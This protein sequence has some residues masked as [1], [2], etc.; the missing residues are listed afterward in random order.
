MYKIK[1]FS[2]FTH[3]AETLLSGLS[4]EKVRWSEIA[5]TLRVALD[6]VIG[7]IL[8][9]SAFIAF[10]GC[11][12]RPYRNNLLSNWIG[13][14]A[15]LDIQC[16]EHFKLHLTLNDSAEIRYWTTSEL[17]MDDYAVESAIVVRNSHR[18]P[19][20]IDPQGIQTNFSCNYEGLIN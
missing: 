9:S 13:K 14:C 20:I 2:D 10:L 1:T 5:S 8:L 16:T 12:P 15:E 11:F 3:R 19:L 6:N 18:Y 7:D 17:P 4:V